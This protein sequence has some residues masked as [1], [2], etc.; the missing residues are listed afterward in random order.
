MLGYNDKGFLVAMT[1]RIQQDIC[2]DNHVMN[3]LVVK[4]TKVQL[5]GCHGNKFVLPQVSK[6]LYTLVNNIGSTLVALCCMQPWVQ[7][8]NVLP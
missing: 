6:Y 2:H 7:H 8:I 3:L 4:A 1:T 5:Y